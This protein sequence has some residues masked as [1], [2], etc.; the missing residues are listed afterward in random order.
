MFFFSLHNN[1]YF[2]AGWAKCGGYMTDEKLPNRL[3]G[4]HH[5]QIHCPRLRKYSNN[6]HKYDWKLRE[7]FHK[8]R[9]I[10][11]N[12]LEIDSIDIYITGL[13]TVAI[14]K[15]IVLPTQGSF[16]FKFKSFNLNH[17]LGW[18]IIIHR[19]KKKTRHSLQNGKTYR[20]MCY[21]QNY[22]YETK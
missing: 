10:F 3:T 20:K 19:L 13:S 8:E 15:Y 5:R 17:F 7:I 22:K 12:W 21:R 16:K 14:Y 2:F 1:L 4:P 6:F 9:Q 11:K 18:Q